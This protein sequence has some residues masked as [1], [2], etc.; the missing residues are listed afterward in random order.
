VVRVALLKPGADLSLKGWLIF[1]AP[2]EKR[3][4]AI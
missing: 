1:D 3:N 2:V 4:P